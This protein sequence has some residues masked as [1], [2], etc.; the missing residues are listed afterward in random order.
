MTQIIL[1]VA[2]SFLSVQP[3]TIG[4]GGQAERI[5]I[6]SEGKTMDSAASDRAARCKYFLIFG[7]EG[8][9]VEVIENPNRDVL[10]DAGL[11]TVDLL[12]GKDVRLLVANRV[13]ARMLAALKKE[14]IARIEFTGTVEDAL[15]FARE[16]K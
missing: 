12:V 1:L 6:A 16:E 15:A 11:A 9:L 7:L 13:G 3:I 5:A 4:Q 10:F 8:K 14:R 2:F